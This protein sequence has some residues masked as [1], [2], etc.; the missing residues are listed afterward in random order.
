MTKSLLSNERVCYRCGTTLNLQKH[1]IYNGGLRKLADAYG[2]WVWL[3][4]DCHVGSRGV[5]TTHGGRVYWD[6]LKAECQRKFEEEYTHEEFMKL[7]RRNN[8]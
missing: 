2:C 5:H 1:H 6:S 4:M 7:F 8:L 3:C